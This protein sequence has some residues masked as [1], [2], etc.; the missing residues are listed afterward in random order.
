MNGCPGLSGQYYIHAGNGDD[1]RW[2]FI[3][4]VSSIYGSREAYLRYKYLP[5]KIT[6]DSHIDALYVKTDVGGVHVDRV[7]CYDGINIGCSDGAVVARFIYPLRTPGGN[8]GC[9]KL[10]T[11]NILR[12]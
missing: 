10:T 3:G 5:V 6:L 2:V 1:A 4:M 11:E 12:I 9:A 7:I 8:G